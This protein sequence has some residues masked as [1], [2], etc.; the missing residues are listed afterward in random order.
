LIKFCNENDLKSPIVTSTSKEGNVEYDGLKLQFI[1]S[2]SYAYTVGKK[3]LD[4][5]VNK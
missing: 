4:I 1:P 5:K 2:S 3:T